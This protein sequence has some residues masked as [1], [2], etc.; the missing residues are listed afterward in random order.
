MPPGIVRRTL[1]T[2]RQRISG[3]VL[4][5]PRTPPSW[6]SQ[7]PPP[8][9]TANAVPTLSDATRPNHPHSGWR[10]TG[11]THP[12]AGLSGVKHR[13]PTKALL[14]RA[15]EP[16]ELPGG[17]APDTASRPTRPHPTRRRPT[18]PCVPTAGADGQAGTPPGRG[19]R[20]RNTPASGLRAGSRPRSRPRTRT[21]TYR[22]HGRSP[23]RPLPGCRPP[24]GGPC[25]PVR[26][27]PDPGRSHH[28][29]AGGERPPHQDRVEPGTRPAPQ[30]AC[31]AP[32]SQ[33]RASARRSALDL[34]AA[35]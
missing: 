30:A 2:F 8:T 11:G 24:G 35:V 7:L 20:G 15:D 22:P 17:A 4:A 27:Q 9:D 19:P 14:E 18:P 1:P 28:S 6:P 3:R 32:A 16:A 13:L 31:P 21:D 10:S 34:G 25:P 23:P 26:H 12:G 33:R 5:R 29:I